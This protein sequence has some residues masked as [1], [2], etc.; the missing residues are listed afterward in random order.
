M[1]VVELVEQFT[2]LYLAAEFTL[3][4]APDVARRTL[5]EVWDRKEFRKPRRQWAR[6]VRWTEVVACRIS[7]TLPLQPRKPRPA[8]CAVADEFDEAD[9]ALIE[10]VMA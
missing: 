8:E 6:C 10:S 9:I 1:T 3:S 7:G 4:I 2:S 5:Q